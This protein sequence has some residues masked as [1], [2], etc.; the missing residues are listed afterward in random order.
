MQAASLQ[1][2]YLKLHIDEGS[3]EMSAITAGPANLE[4]PHIVWEA[5]DDS[6]AGS[7][8]HLYGFILPLLTSLSD[9]E[10]QQTRKNLIL[11]FSKPLEKR[12]EHQN[13]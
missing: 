2:L 5:T 4:T 13:I 3:V 12:C 6:L 1:E 8:P 7:L 11:H 10:I 9:L